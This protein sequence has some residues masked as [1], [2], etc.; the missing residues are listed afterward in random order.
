MIVLVI[1][2]N[3][4]V[5]KKLVMELAEWDEVDFVYVF[6]R[7]GTGLRHKK[8][9]ILVGDRNDPKDLTAVPW[10]DIEYVVDMC[11]YKVEQL[12][13][14]LK[15]VKK[16]NYTFV[17]S[18]AAVLDPV[19]SGFGEYGEQKR[20]VE[21]KV[22]K[23]IWKNCIVRPTY[24]LSSPGSPSHR[25]RDRYFLDCLYHGVPIQIDGDGLSLIH[26]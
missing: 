25:S 9:R 3:R 15:Y 23:E 4:F 10:H 14:L 22:R 11:L 2:G 5:G 7:S 19:E 8:V 16:K 13:P 21:E 26:I 6:N 17:S 24:V 18:I 12:N 1:G 20:L